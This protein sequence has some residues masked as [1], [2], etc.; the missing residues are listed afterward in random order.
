MVPQRGIYCQIALVSIAL[1]QIEDKIDKI[2]LLSPQGIVL[3]Y[4]I[5]G[6]QSGVLLNRGGS[7]ATIGNIVLS[8]E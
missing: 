1:S 8:T 2:Q 4:E 3:S 5:I 7:L 6:P